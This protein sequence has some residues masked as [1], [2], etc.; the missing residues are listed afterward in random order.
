MQQRG[1]EYHLQLA[2]HKLGC[3]LKQQAIQNMLESQQLH[4]HKSYHIPG[5][6]QLRR[7]LELPGLVRLLRRGP[8]QDLHGCQRL[9]HHR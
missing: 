2:V 4:N 3:M 6:R 9:R 5:M 1:R 8:D 7:E